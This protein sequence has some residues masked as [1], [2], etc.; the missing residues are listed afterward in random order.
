MAATA[1]MEPMFTEDLDVIVLVDTDD[2]YLAVFQSIGNES[3]GQEGMP[4]VLGGV[5]VQL[6]PSTI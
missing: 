6:F 5:P 2:D 4:Q 1:Y 3:D